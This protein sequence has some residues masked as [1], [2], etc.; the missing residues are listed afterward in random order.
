MN[1]FFLGGLLD[2]AAKGIK[3]GNA[4]K[5][6]VN[7]YQANDLRQKGME[8]AR[9]ARELEINGAITSNGVAP[10]A[11]SN[12]AASVSADTA[13]G[14]NDAPTTTAQQPAAPSA[15]P[16][17]VASPA[18]QV[19]STPLAD[20]GQP[21]PAVPGATL[22]QQQSVAA[23]NGMPTYTVG[24][25]AYTDPAQAR[26]EAT[27]NASSTTD[28]FIKN[29]SAKMRD[30]YV[31]NGD[32][33]TAQKWDKWSEDT[34]NKAGIKLWAG[35]YTAA[36]GGDWDTAADKFGKYY[37][38]HINDG[39]DYVGHKN[40]MGEDGELVGFAA[41][42]RNKATG[43]ES[44]MQMTPQSMLKMGAANNPQALF[45][46]ETAQQTAL[47]AANAKIAEEQT[48][49]KGRVELEGIKSGAAAKLQVSKDQA[50]LDRVVTRE[51]LKGANAS[52]Q[53]RQE[54]A[55]TV[56]TLKDNGYTDAEVKK[57][58]PAI[59]KIGEYKKTTD[60]S[61]RANLVASELTKSDPSFARLADDKK[62]EKIL[63]I[64]KAA[65]GASKA[66]SGSAPA[67]TPAPPAATGV[68]GAAPAG[69]TLVMDVKTGRMVYK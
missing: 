11:Q 22:P 55:G 17:A 2:G 47:N 14:V 64:M 51:Q 32:L 28:L 60:P 39:V 36:Q 58:I 3:I 49:Q 38:D 12:Q 26:A 66:L 18:G 53:A 30:F 68:V 16:I 24:G 69:K 56:Q 41:T 7:E 54:T 35:A 15:T 40:V 5:G 46:S 25:K 37:T 9:Q 45:A 63:S 67:A 33:E 23:A 21:Q 10:T 29:T 52:D 31:Q 8:E 65:D 61:E 57:M 34:K 27:K 44:E 1:G 20:Q 48:K 13:P 59:L 6:A 4:I 19:T 43:K 62:Q 42:L 50:S